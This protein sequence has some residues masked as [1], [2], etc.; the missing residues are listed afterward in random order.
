MREASLNFTDSNLLYNLFPFLLNISD[1]LFSFNE[2]YF[3][4]NAFHYGKSI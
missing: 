3:I 1:F 4:M 2:N